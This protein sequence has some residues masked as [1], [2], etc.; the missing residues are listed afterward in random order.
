MAYEKL[1]NATYPGY[2]KACRGK[3]ERGDFILYDMFNKTARHKRCVDVQRK[4]Q[5]NKN[6]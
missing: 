1:I 2:C 5:E 6:G 3:I 4:Q